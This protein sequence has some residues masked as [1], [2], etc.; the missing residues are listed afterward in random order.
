MWTEL[1]S[2]YEYTPEHYPEAGLGD[3]NYCRNP[4]NEY[5]VWCFTTYIEYED[6]YFAWDYCDVG[7]R[8]LSCDNGKRIPKCLGQCNLLALL[9]NSLKKKTRYR[10]CSDEGHA[11]IPR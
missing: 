4:D 3:H 6:V 8:A 11:F 9:G 7:I 1:Q 5:G 10:L 2:P